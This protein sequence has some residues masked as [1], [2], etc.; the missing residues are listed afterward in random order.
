M[1]IE[2]FLSKLRFGGLRLRLVCLLLVGLLPAIVAL[3]YLLKATYLEKQEQV[4][5]RLL[6]RTRTLSLGMDKELDEISAALQA[7][8]TSPAIDS[9][10]YARF[11]VQLRM[12][13]SRYPSVDI[14]LADPTGQQ[15]VNSYMPYGPPLPKRN[16]P[17]RLQ[18][19]FETGKTS[20]SGLYTG[21]I[22]GRRFVSVDVPVIRDGRVMTCPHELYHSLC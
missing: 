20:I 21:A 12:M 9:G 3:G 10:D 22:T 11:H 7:L 15:L 5:I 8:A 18:Q 2:T 17:D 1:W 13:R 14:I 16:V 4:S 6:E 19:L